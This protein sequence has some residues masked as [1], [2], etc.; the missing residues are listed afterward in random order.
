MASVDATDDTINRW[1]VKWYAFDPDRRQRCHRIVSAY[2]NEAEFRAALTA[3][4]ERLEDLK[5]QGRAEQRERIT[6][7]H[8]PAGYGKRMASERIVRKRAQR[9]VV[10]GGPTQRDEERGLR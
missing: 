2:D 3:A 6:G 1:I 7:S 10:T 9:R 4:H 5:R 8:L